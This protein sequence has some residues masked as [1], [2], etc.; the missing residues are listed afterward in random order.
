[1]AVFPDLLQVGLPT[2]LL[3]IGTGLIVAE[4]FAPGAH[5]FVA[6]VSLFAAGL[7]GFVLPPALGIFNVLILAA[8]VLATGGATLYAYRQFDIYTGAGVDQTSDSDSLR[9]QSGRVT[10]RVTPREGEVKLEDGGFNP[11]Y[12]ARSIDGEIPKETEVIVLDPGGGNVLT[13]EAVENITD[14]IDRELARGRR[15]ADTETGAAGETGR[16]GQTGQSGD[17]DREPER[18]SGSHA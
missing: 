9:G 5:F 3:L 15:A 11:F 8:V 17:R 7:V 14:D 16:A 6:G 1:M 18:E 12:R 2:L 13:V 10:E 4:A